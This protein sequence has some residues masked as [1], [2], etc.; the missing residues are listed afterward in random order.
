MQERKDEHA[1]IG[2]VNLVVD[3]VAPCHAV[4]DSRGNCFAHVEVNAE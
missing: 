3:F 2:L 4:T 1:V